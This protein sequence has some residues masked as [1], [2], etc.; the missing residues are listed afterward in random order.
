M[1]EA[2]FLKQSQLNLNRL[3]MTTRFQSSLIIA[4]DRT[5]S[6]RVKSAIFHHVNTIV[7][8]F[9]Q[10]SKPNLHILYMI[11]RSSMGFIVVQIEPFLVK[12]V[13]FP[14]VNTIE[15]E[16]LTNINQTCTDSWP[17]PGVKFSSSF[18]FNIPILL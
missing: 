9:L 1:I 7:A 14:L 4:P 5:T 10:Q 18:F 6:T 13:L 17:C 3:Y 11:T 12:I 16:F 8:P 15:S 2:T